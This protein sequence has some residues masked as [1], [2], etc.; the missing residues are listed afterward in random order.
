VPPASVGASAPRPPPPLLLCR[1]LPL[2]ADRCGSH[3]HHLRA[4]VGKGGRSQ[5]EPRN[6][7]STSPSEAAR[8]SRGSSTPLE[9][10]QNQPFGRAPLGAGALPNRA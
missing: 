2:A 4:T 8:C 1:L 9:P 10:L 6:R 3:G 5:V 7:G